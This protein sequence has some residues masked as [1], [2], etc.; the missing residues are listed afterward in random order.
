MARNKPKTRNFL[1]LRGYG[2]D[3]TGND[4]HEYVIAL[5]A[6][7]YI[8]GHTFS[9]AGT[10]RNHVRNIHRF[11]IPSRINGVNRPLNRYC[12]Y[13][14]RTNTDGYHELH[15][16]CPSCWFH[17]PMSE[18]AEFYDHTI[19]EHDPRHIIIVNENEY[20]RGM[21]TRNSQS[22][23]SGGEEE[24]PNSCSNSR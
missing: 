23:V 9:S 3:K 8:C 5:D 24:V 11:D 18:P 10:A 14:T 4:T 12:E 13:V 19:V 16:S 7:C 21:G 20:D 1:K 15:Y 2:F 22:Y 17:C 6:G